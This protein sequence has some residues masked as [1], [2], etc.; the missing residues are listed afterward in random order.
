VERGNG[1]RLM[2]GGKLERSERGEDERREG[3]VGG[4]RVGRGGWGWRV[5][6]NVWG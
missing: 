4:R 3:A 6:G 2:P 1:V 5:G